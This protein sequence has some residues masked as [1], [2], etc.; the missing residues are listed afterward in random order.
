MTGLRSL[1]SPIRHSSFDI[2][3]LAVDTDPIVLACGIARFDRVPPWRWL[4]AHVGESMHYFKRIQAALQEAG[5]S[6]HHTLVSWAGPVEKRAKEL[7]S[8]VDS[9]LALT[10]RRKVHIIAHSMGG[11]DARWMIAKLGYAPKVCSLTTIATPH[12]GSPVAD[13]CVANRKSARG[14]VSWLQRNGLD[15][16]GLYDLTTEASARRN[17]A[18]APLEAN[19]GVV[20]RTWAG[21]AAFWST[22]DWLK[23]KY[24]LLKYVYDEPLSDGLVPLRSARWKHEYFQGVL[25]W[26]HFN[27]T[28]W[29]TPSRMTAGDFS[30]QRLERGV[31]EFYVRVARDV[32]AL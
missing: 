10:G 1:E 28:G 17:E 18:L 25:P 12:H 16:R 26:D 13:W 21:R 14:I 29:W 6:A 5:F 20:Y 31:R 32:A 22:F 11:L 3:L 30:P 19:N 7:G 23:P 4:A 9:V 15:L 24:L 2:R 27:L 8:E